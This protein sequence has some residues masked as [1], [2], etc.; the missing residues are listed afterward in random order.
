MPGKSVRKRL[1][2]LAEPAVAVYG[3]RDWDFEILCAL[4]ARSARPPRII[5]GENPTT[6]VF[7][8]GLESIRAGQP[9]PLFLDVLELIAKSGSDVLR[10]VFPLLRPIAPRSVMAARASASMAQDFRKY[11]I[12]YLRKKVGHKVTYEEAVRGFW[13]ERR[14]S[15]LP[16]SKRKLQ[17][18][19]AEHF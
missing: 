18:V 5:E 14:K 7:R 1:E 11:L 16:L 19:L 2:R 8:V 17:R 13:L 10:T 6:Q 15:G 3:G 12:R 4:E 9:S